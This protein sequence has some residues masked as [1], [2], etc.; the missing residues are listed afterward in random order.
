MSKVGF[1][2]GVLAAASFAG[3]GGGSKPSPTA[4]GPSPAQVAAQQRQA[5]KIK[6]EAEYAKCKSDLGP[7]VTSL[8]DLDSRLGVG[9]SYS[10]YTNKVGDV[11]V[12]YD[13]VPFKSLDVAC[14]GGVGI[15]A[16]KSFN[17]H[18][19][20]ATL[21]GNCQS[22]INCSNDSIKPTL[23]KYWLKASVLTDRAKNNLEAIKAP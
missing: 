11:K 10:E 1:V 23:Q 18:A 21:W 20:A 16:E 22:D 13:N 9:L 17:Q 3:C 19:K 8:S 2:T 7:L 5:A 4:Q 6:A 15:P 12:A 14:V